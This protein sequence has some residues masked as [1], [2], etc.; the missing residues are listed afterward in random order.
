[1]LSWVLKFFVETYRGL[2]NDTYRM[3]LIL[4]HP[5]YLIT[6]AC[7]HIASVYKEKD[8][9]TWFEELSVDM[10][11]VSLCLALLFTRAWNVSLS[12]LWPFLNTR[13]CLMGML[14]T[15]AGEEYRNGDIRFLWEPQNVHGRESSRC[16]QQTCCDK[17]IKESYL[18]LVYVFVPLRTVNKYVLAEVSEMRS[19]RSSWFN[20]VCLDYSYAQ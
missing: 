14:W 6:L 18:R 7:I 8:I 17:P 4:I 10:N 15:L 1:M 3:D 9:R 19:F 5:P 16:L 2:V 12:T 13:S 11:I 20:H